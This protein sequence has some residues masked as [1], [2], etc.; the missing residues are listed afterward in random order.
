MPAPTLG[1]LRYR[2]ATPLVLAAAVAATWHSTRGAHTLAAQA[3]PKQPE[4]VA[5]GIRVV[6]PGF[7]ANRNEVRAFNEEPGTALALVVRMPAGMGIIDLDEDDCRLTAF[8]DDVGTDLM[9]HARFGPFPKT[10]DDGSAGLVEVESNL[11]PAAGATHLLAEGTL[12]FTSSPGS[13]PQRVAKVK[14]EK[15]QAFKLGATPMTI[16]EV[17]TDGE[18]KEISFGLPR[19]ALSAIREVKFLDAKGQPLESRRTGRGYMNEAGS[20]DYNVKGAGGVVTIEF[21]VW[22][23]PTQ[24]KVPFKLKAGLALR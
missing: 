13:K 3:T 24:Q 11:R 20:M 1:R 4:V 17:T 19:S 14:L 10:S 2:I 8:G 9:E 15:G 7:G 5:A 23:K 6:G 22:Q 16:D 12:V 21:D 18:E